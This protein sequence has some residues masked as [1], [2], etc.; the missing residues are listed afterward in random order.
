M[1]LIVDS[2]SSKADWVVVDRGITIGQFIT[3]GINPFF[4]TSDEILELV[5]TTFNSVLIAGKIENIY[6]YGAGCIKNHNTSIVQDGLQ[7]YFAAAHIEVEDDM[8]GA[9]HA[10]FGNNPGIACILGT[11][12]NS[13][14]FDGSSI[15]EKISAL[16]Y[17]LGDEASGAYFGKILI[18]NYFKK[19]MPVDLAEK[20]N[21]EY[22]PIEREILNIVYRQ[23][24]PNRFLAKFTHFLSK[25]IDHTYVKSVLA[26]GFEAFIANNIMK[27]SDYNNYSVGFVGSMA[28][29]FSEILLEVGAKHKIKIEKIIEKPIDGLVQYHIG[30]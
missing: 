12:A 20:F 23:P 3:K 26:S 17:I 21:Q 15:T 19:I 14:K 10:V 28:Y 2:G 5:K 6:F 11:G 30:N 13:C 29:H 22:Q 9:A 16:G 4:Q 25:N 8:I 1:R 7:Q 24:Y 18:N 27:Y